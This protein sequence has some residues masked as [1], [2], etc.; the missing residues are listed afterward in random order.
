MDEGLFAAEG[1]D[2]QMAS[3]SHGRRSMIVCAALVVPPDSGVYVPQELAR[4]M[5][6]LDALTADDFNLGRISSGSRPRFVAEPR[7]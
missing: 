2:L 1:L 7:R 6:G 5:V 3:R 4:R